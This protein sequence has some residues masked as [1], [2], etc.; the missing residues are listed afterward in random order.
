M[1][2]LNYIFWSKYCLTK[3]CSPFVNL[4]KNL[5][6]Y[7]KIIKYLLQLINIKSVFYNKFYFKN[8]IV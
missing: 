7:G 2:N 1:H 8:Q 4:N 6:S 5:D 3:E